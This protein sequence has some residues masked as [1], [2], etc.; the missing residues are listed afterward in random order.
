MNGNTEY[1]IFLN[2]KEVRVFLTGTMG[3]SGC[4][5]N[6]RLLHLI[7]QD[8]QREQNLPDVSVNEP[9]FNHFLHAHDFYGLFRRN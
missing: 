6:I 7:T 2:D 4:V 3:M 9:A 5:E 8:Y 1:Q